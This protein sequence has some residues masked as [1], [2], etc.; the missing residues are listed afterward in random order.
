MAIFIVVLACAGRVAVGGVVTW[1]WP[2]GSVK[3]RD[4]AR[5]RTG[6]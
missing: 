2:E 1:V 6:P 4:I 5:V 3:A